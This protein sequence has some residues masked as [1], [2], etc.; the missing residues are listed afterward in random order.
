MLFINFFKQVINDLKQLSL[1]NKNTS[2][3]SSW[4]IVSHIYND[5]KLNYSSSFSC[6]IILF[7]KAAL[8]SNIA[9]ALINQRFNYSVRFF[10]VHRKTKN[11]ILSD[12][13]SFILQELSEMRHS[14]GQY[15]LVFYLIGVWIIFSFSQNYIYNKA[16]SI[17][18]QR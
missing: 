13:F 10:P 12:T 1:Q 14:S 15:M 9:I 7:S 3:K 2:Y 17:L 6:I 5:I 16:I 8:R 11:Q 4:S 18:F